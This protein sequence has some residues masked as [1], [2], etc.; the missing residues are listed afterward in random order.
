M[1]LRIGTK[2]GFEDNTERNNDKRLELFTSLKI[3][4]F[5][6]LLLYLRTRLETLSFR[7]LTI[8]FKTKE[9]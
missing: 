8:R 3:L 9:H 4:F 7:N 5:R 1:Y 2:K 6:Q